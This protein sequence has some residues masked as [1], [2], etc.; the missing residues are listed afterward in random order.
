MITMR[1]PRRGDR[2]LDRQRSHFQ[3]RPN[4]KTQSDGLRRY[5]LHKRNDK[6]VQEAHPARPM[7]HRRTGNPTPQAAPIDWPKPDH[8]P[9]DAC[10]APVDHVLR[11]AHE[12][13]SDPPLDH[14]RLRHGRGVLNHGHCPKDHHAIFPTPHVTRRVHHP[15]MADNALGQIQECFPHLLRSVPHPRHPTTSPTSIRPLL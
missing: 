6:T 2:T 14:G 4:S 9:T 5:I 13:R 11:F 12:T 15:N 8:P 10:R 3:H 1:R 7:P